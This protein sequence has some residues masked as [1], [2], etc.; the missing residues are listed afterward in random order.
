MESHNK[1]GAA[2]N[3]QVFSMRAVYIFQVIIRLKRQIQ[4]RDEWNFRYFAYKHI[5]SSKYPI[6]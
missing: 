1:S 3:D 5:N 4:S 6:H 2:Q